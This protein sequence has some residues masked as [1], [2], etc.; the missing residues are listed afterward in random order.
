MDYSSKQLQFWSYNKG[1]NNLSAVYLAWFSGRTGCHFACNGHGLFPQLLPLL[2]LSFSMCLCIKQRPERTASISVAPVV[3]QWCKCCNSHFQ[4][5]TML[6]IY[7]HSC[8]DGHQNAPTGRSSQKLLIFYELH[9]VL[10]AFFFSASMLYLFAVSLLSCKVAVPTM[11]ALRCE[12][13]AW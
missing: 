1:I 4:L 10:A 13:V 2:L 12:V 9:S 5:V 11:S 3:P 6:L 8:R 7:T